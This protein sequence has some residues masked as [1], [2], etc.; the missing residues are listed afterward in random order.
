MEDKDIVEQFNKN[1]QEVVKAQLNSYK[2][3]K[4][5]DTHVWAQ[6][7]EVATKKGLTLNRE[8]YPQFRDLVR[9]LGEALGASE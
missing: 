1:A 3:H 2:G 4:L 5:F 6:N 8:L 7:G 9:K